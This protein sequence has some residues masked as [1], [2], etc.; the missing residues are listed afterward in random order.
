MYQK[1]AEKAQAEQGNADK[2][3]SKKDDD[4]IIVEDPKDNK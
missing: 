3:S 2:G 4:E 1:A